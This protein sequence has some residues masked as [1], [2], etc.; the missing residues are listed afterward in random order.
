MRKQGAEYMSAP[1]ILWQIVLVF[2]FL[3]LKIERDQYVHVCAGS[4]VNGAK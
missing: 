2:A 4:E 3:Y 1:W